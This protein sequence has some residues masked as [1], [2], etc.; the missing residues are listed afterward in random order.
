M[1][2]VPSSR[3]DRAAELAGRSHELD[4]V[5]SFL[6]RAADHGGAFLVT[7]EPGVGKSV[8]LA[9]AGR[10]ATASGVRLLRAAGVEFEAEVGFAALH[11]LLLPLHDEMATLPVRH[12]NALL[13]ALGLDAEPA[14]DG[15]V[16]STAALALLH[17]AARRGPLLVVVD[18]L[19]WL[20]RSSAGVL[21]FVARRLEG[22]R[23]GFLAAGRS[24]SDSFLLSAGLRQHDVPPL[25][26]QAARRL[27]RHRFPTLAAPVRQRVLAA[28][29]GNPLALLELPATLTPAQRRGDVPLPPVLPLNGH[30]R[31]LFTDRVRRLPAGTRDLLV[32]LALDGTG[33]VRALR[34]AAPGDGWL[35]ELAPAER[36]RLVHVDASAA[37]VVFRHPLVG[38]AAVELATSAERRRAHAGLADTLTDDSE[39]RAWHVAEAALAPEESAAGM[40]ELAADRALQTGD[41]VQ[42][43][44]ALLRAADLS[45]SGADRARR[46]AAAAYVGADVAGQLSSVPD[47]LGEARR[48][49]PGT[50]GSLEAT[51]AAAYH[52]LNGDGD[53]NTAHLMLVQGIESALERGQNGAALEEAVHSLMVVCHFRGRAQPWQPFRSVLTRLDPELSPVLAVSGRVYGAAAAARATDLAALDAL[54]ATVNQEVDPTR[55][56]RMGMAAFYVDRLAACRPALWRV[57][58]DGRDGGAAASAVNALMM[59]CHEAFREGRWEQA[60]RAAE[61]GV[62]WSERLGYQLAALPGIYCQALLAAARGDEDAAR[63]RTEEL[64]AWATPR[65]VMLLEHFA[66]RAQALA[67]LGRGDYEEAFR[68]TSRISRPGHLPPHVPLALWIARD[69]VEAAVRT[70]RW[71][72]AE[73]HVAAIQRAEVF[74]L[75]PR[76]ALLAAGA[77]ALVASGDD[78]DRH[79]REALALDGGEQ[80]PFERARI[81]LSYGEHLRRSR[82]IQDSRRHLAEALE[83]FQR[84]DATPWVTRTL[85]ELR[86]TG[87]LRRSSTADDRRATLTEQEHQIASLAASG[88]SNKQI[89]TRLYLSHRTVSG[90]LYRIFPKL[91]VSSRAAL[92]DA[93]TNAP[94]PD[95]RVADRPAAAGTGRQCA[96]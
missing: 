10:T 7:A 87:Q 23:I 5:R 3:E 96:L 57:V 21:G 2:D 22:S 50:G 85:H 25:D 46:L 77:A 55:I 30:L 70:G 6:T 65:G 34:A 24:E 68:L 69:L 53:V 51:V 44:Q 91:G 16:V 74:G 59:L 11:Q 54:L 4:L 28:A 1:D 83:V 76:L 43:V 60:A 27:L 38:A 86:I 39:R 20:D 29:Q 36:D 81:Q 26:E 8:L 12:R 56:V 19:Q 89:G 17:A 94:A 80:F 58:R 14:T 33:D 52:L 71:A 9:E 40:L 45:P 62:A 95:G 79:Y 37:R 63:S 41:P 47:R 13:G 31:R 88:L 75:S 64:R 84:L 67:A 18:D 32:L 92:R 82:A 78:A 15:L 90:H 42:A 93:L 73:A 61:E 35:E 48:A 66:G 49:D 72:E